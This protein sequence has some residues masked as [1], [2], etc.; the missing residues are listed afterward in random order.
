MGSLARVGMDAFRRTA[1]N[2]QMARGVSRSLVQNLSKTASPT[3]SPTIQRASHL[4]LQLIQEAGNFGA[5]V[6][7]GVFNSMRDDYVKKELFGGDSLIGNTMVKLRKEAMGKLESN[8]QA[9]ASDTFMIKEDFE[10]MIG[11]DR[12]V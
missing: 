12:F 1:T 6:G 9:L 7:K 2:P 11:P 4:G 5:E 10:G 8:I 3:G